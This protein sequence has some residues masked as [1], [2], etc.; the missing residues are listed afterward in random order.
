M[1]MIA[2]GVTGGAKGK[3]MRVTGYK[4]REA[5]RKWQRQRDAFAG[6][7]TDSLLAFPG[8]KK[9]T[10]EELAEQITKC[11]HAMADLQV[12][13]AAYNIAV[14]VQIE[15]V[16]AA[17][18]L[19]DCVKQIGGYERLVTMWTN[20]AK[21]KKSRYASFTDDPS[22]RDADKLVAQ[23]TVS[24]EEAARRAAQADRTRVAFVEALAVGN[25]TPH[26]LDL[27]PS[28]FE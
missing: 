3:G 11:E 4:L 26:D 24:Y 17:L 18:T 9:P 15:G 28:L 7:F 20:A 19:L 23:R 13:Q 1:T 8:E 2:N 10:P 16:P 27:H 14:H 6:Q 12:A 22:L 5:L 25:A 21:S